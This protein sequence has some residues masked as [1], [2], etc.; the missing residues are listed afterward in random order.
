VT[1]REDESRL[2]DRRA[3]DNVAWLR[4]FSLSLLKQ[5]NDKECIAM[6]R[7]RKAG[8]NVNDMMQVPGVPTL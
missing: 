5:Q 1:F 4:R 3:A 6:R 8:W 7:R 2:G